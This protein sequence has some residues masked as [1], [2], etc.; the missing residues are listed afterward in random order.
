MGKYVQ[1]KHTKI[2]FVK[3]KPKLNI[4][5]GFFLEVVGVLFILLLVIG[6]LYLNVEVSTAG[7]IIFSV[8]GT[9]FLFFGVRLTSARWGQ[10]FD[11]D[12][13]R[14]IRWKSSVFGHSE[15]VFDCSP[16]E[17]KQL[18]VFMPKLRRYPKFDVHLIGPGCEQHLFISDQRDEVQAFLLELKPHIDLPV[19]ES[20]EEY[21]SLAGYFKGDREFDYF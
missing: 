20:V 16:L 10:E 11:L 8:L 1:K 2:I 19:L 21:R 15:T 9:L 17:D 12:S 3:P 4:A 7:V 18:L 14:M 13:N 6:F 5:F